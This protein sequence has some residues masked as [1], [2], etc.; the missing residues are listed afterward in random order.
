MPAPEG[1]PYRTAIVNQTFAERYFKNA[2]PI[3]RHI[4][5]GTNPGTPTP[6]EIVG[7]AKDSRYVGIREDPRPQMFFPYPGRMENIAFYVRT[8]QDPDVIVQSMRRALSA[9]RPACAH[10]RGDDA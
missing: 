4:G 5:F 9:T 8:A 3:G 10:V 1:W 6:I 7:V 2:N